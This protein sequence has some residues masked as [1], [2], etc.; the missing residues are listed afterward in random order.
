MKFVMTWI[1]T[2]VLAVILAPI[3]AFLI[4][5]ITFFSSFLAFIAGVNGGLMRLKYPNNTQPAQEEDIW[6][7]HVK[8]LQ[9]KEQQK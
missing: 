9:E 3:V 7:R 6:D 2:M 4:A 5:F 8:K 1:F